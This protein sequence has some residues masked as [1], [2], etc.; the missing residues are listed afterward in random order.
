M[1]IKLT[2]LI[3]SLLVALFL[4]QT[5]LARTPP[6]SFSAQFVT[7]SKDNSR[8]T[9]LANDR[10]QINIVKMDVA[11]GKII[12]K[13]P[14]TNS[15]RSTPF[16]A[17]PDG[18]K[19]LASGPKGIDVIHN[20]TGKVLRTLPHPAKMR[21]WRFASIQSEDG[22]LLAVP[23]IS[24]NLRKIYLLHTGT[25][26]VVHT[27]DLLKDEKWQRYPSINAIGFNHK[28]NL[29]AYE[30]QAD[31]RSIL[32]LY[33]I[34]KRA[35]VFRVEIAYGNHEYGKIA[36]SKN[37]KYL[38]VTAVNRKSIQL[39]NLQTHAVQDLKY[40]YASFAN[41]NRDDNVIILQYH[42]NT[43]TVHNVAT[44]KKQT[45]PLKFNRAKG[46]YGGGYT[47]SADRSLIALPF[48]SQNP[49]NAHQFLIMNAQTGQIIRAIKHRE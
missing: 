36:F 23:S 42:S 21:D 12:K 38:I 30:I 34:Y 48:R 5:L 40:T 3:T 10:K 9:Y 1:N 4:H 2:K 29:I 24:P 14:Y 19:F 27:I 39:V 15:R 16:A 7:F 17:T 25:G 20:D 35:E 26:K 28:R 41:F 33:D 47:Q 6:P 43:A 49:K 22:V 18:F 11:T 37:G 31:G 8:L 32:H 46:I 45:K 13:V 44:G